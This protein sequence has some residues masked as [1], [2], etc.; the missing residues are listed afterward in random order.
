MIVR[1]DPEDNRQRDERC[2]CRRVEGIGRRQ[3]TPRPVARNLTW[4]GDGGCGSSYVLLNLY[5]VLLVGR[6]GRATARSWDEE[7]AADCERREERTPRR[8]SSAPDMNAPSHLHEMM[9]CPV[10]DVC[11][12]SGQVRT[13]AGR[14]CSLNKS[15]TPRIPPTRRHTEP[16]LSSVSPSHR[17]S[18]WQ[19]QSR[20]SRTAG[21]RLA[22]RTSAGCPGRIPR[23]S[24]P[25]R[26]QW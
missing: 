12:H 11:A 17:R 15:D 16:P 18:P 22:R 10:R 9:A 23:G 24:R 14:E 20:A 2:F 13:V 26:A 21:P 3:P 8:A 6:D 5:L 25:P 4:H 7:R 19:R 1:I